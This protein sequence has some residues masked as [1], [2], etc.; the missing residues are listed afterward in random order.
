M[1]KAN[2]ARIADAQ[3]Q[4]QLISKKGKNYGSS[5][6]YLQVLGS[7]ARGAPNTLYLFTDQKRY[8]FNCGESTQRLAHEH[9]VKLT[10]LDHIFITSKTW[11]NLGGLPGLSL[12]LQDVGVPN[13]TLHGPD[14][15]DELYTATRR[16]VIMTDM[17]VTMAKCSPGEDF[18]DN[19]MTVKYVLL[20][21]ENVLQP[22]LN[23]IIKKP[24]LSNNPNDKVLAEFTHDDTDYYHPD[25]KNT[26]KKNNN[27]KDKAK[28]SPEKDTPKKKI[29]KILNDLQGSSKCTVA[30]ICTL[31]KRLGTLD[32][33]KCV[34]KGVKPGPMLG[35]LKN[36][37]DVI[38]PDGTVVRS[39]DVKTPD[40]PGPVF[41]VLEV[42]DIS[43][44]Q[45][46][47]FSAHFDNGVNP[48]EMVP[49]V[50]VHYT[51][52]H[53]LRHPTYRAFMSM[54]GP[55]TRHL[56]LNEGNSC[57][58]SEAV[59][60]SQHRLHQ[61]DARVFP[62]LRD[63]SVPAVWDDPP[64]AP[65]AHE[66]LDRL[67]DRIALAQ[68]ENIISMKEGNRAE[69]DGTDNPEDGKLNIITGRTLT[70]FHLRPKKDLDRSAE[71]KLH[72]QEYIQESMGVEGFAKSLQQF[73][74]L[75][76]KVRAEGRGAGAEY[77]RVV[78][79]GTGSCIP[80]KT[81]NTSGIVL[82][83]DESRSMLLDCGEGTFGQLVRFYGPKRVNAFLRTLKAVYVSHLHADHHIGLIGV[84]QA[85]RQAFEEVDS[86]QPY[87]PLH[88]LAPGQIVTWLSL[89]DHQFERI[90]DDFVLVPNQTMMDSKCDLTEWGL[91]AATLAD[92]GLARITTCLVAHCPNAFGVA[93]E[94]RGGHKITY[95]GDTIPCDELARIGKDSTL[96]IHEAT[97]EDELA[98][99]ARAKMHSTTSQAIEAGRRMGA[100][101]T[102]LTHFSQR[103]ARVPRLGPRALVGVGVAF[104]N[105]QTDAGTVSQT[106]AGTV[107][108][109]DAGTVSQ[110]DADRCRV[111]FLRPTLVLFLRPTPV[112]FLR[113][114]DAG[115]VSQT[116][117]GTVSQTDAGTVSQ[118]DAGTVSQ[119]DAGTVSQTDAGTVSQ[120][121]AG[122]VSQTDA[123]T[124][125][126]TDAGTVS[127]TDAGTVSQTDAGT[128]S[129]TDAGT[130]SQTD[131]GTVSQTD[132][133]TVSQTDA[134][135]VSQTDAGTVSQTDA[136]TV[137][138]T[139]VVLFLR[140]MLCFSDRRW[141]CFSDRRRYCFSDRRR[142]CFSDRRW[143]CSQTDAGT[144]SQTDAGTVSQ[145]D[146]G[147][148]SQ[149]DAG[150]V[151]QT[152]AG[153]V[154][155][156][157]AGTVS[158]T[159]AGTVSQTDA[160]TV[161]QTDAG[162]VSQTEATVSQTD[163][164]TVSQTDAGTTPVLFLRPT[165]VLF[166]RP[167]LVLFLRPTPVLFLRPT[168][169]LFLRP[170]LVLFLRPTPVLFLRLM[171]VLFLRPTLV[172]FLRP[173][174]VLILRPTPVLFLRPTP[175]LFLRLTL[176]LFLRPTPVLFL[177]LMQ[178]VFLRPTLVLFLR[179]TPVLFLRLMQVLFPRSK[180]LL[181][182]KPT[183]V[184]FLRPMLILWQVTM[185]D[186]P[187]LPH[188]HAPL[189]L[190]FAEHCVDLELKAANRAKRANRGAPST[191][192]V[193]GPTAASSAQTTQHHTGTVGSA[194]TAT[195]D[196][197]QHG[198]PESPPMDPSDNNTDLG[199]ITPA[200]PQGPATDSP[201]DL[202]QLD[203]KIQN[204][205]RRTNEHCKIDADSDVDRS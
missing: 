47:E 71:P 183:L 30:Y 167:T 197:G 132:A 134:G 53:V 35:Q 25:V 100:R 62:L 172:L 148:V 145:T 106:D 84:L 182:L 111:L 70:M 13:I 123:G 195:L 56:V 19:V 29:E 83:I 22:D 99:E 173:T 76:A 52:S 194:H 189:Q 115:T 142:Y 94:L 191:G 159:D 158:Q 42:P 162:T 146:A 137:S 174:P 50:V 179:P 31:K 127:Q 49:S 187:L 110:T 98:E 61:L 153:T 23:P 9:K 63:V 170:T 171:Q 204:V 66:R 68:F 78:F 109:T 147:T 120:T 75:A 16:F 181:T 81:R 45:E 33:E 77:P 104:D 34:E 90:R 117:A 72:I 39:K 180:L 88:L 130:V 192:T 60:R 152:D 48:K 20:R 18:I 125:S 133:G 96:L 101:C 95:S 188:M 17:N 169:V 11:R 164:G 24:K 26:T 41:I 113:L 150:T 139:D 168:P 82:Q 57:L 193:G 12:T 92:L 155:Q 14:G 154:S 122:T 74:E 43:Y 186:L 116:D 8:L 124:V 64:A 105:M 15:L 202:N 175:V 5:I 91:P 138:Q 102:L 119:T 80:S 103:Y 28:A 2:S 149:T 126:Q 112:L 144:V 198:L 203:V 177:T 10:R 3:R 199:S 40:D 131:A 157:D 178:V 176:V 141:Y 121:D 156:T 89:Y 38:L 65:A 196:V 107:S 135:T 1:P 44:L 205:T 136:G 85:R 160:G 128:V 185:E 163:A 21:P 87:Q 79:L 7:G 51:P 6:V 32:L 114:T 151:S 4:R 67:R 201:M 27:I 108:I 54:F 190:M 140:L 166:L 93:V 200:D 69:G 46:H 37:L 97:M 55:A 73:H 118:T 184:L 129:Q 165:P 58:G 86:R 161:S 36:G 59:H 143:Y